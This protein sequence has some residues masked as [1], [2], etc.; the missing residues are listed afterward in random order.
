MA[1]Y[2]LLFGGGS[3]PEGEAAQAQV[4]KAWEAWFTELGSAVADPGNPFTPAAK[5]ISS[6]GS[7]GDAAASA[8]GY[9]V[10][11]ADSLDL[12]AKLATGCPVLQGGATITVF[13]TFEVM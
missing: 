5:K 3:M 13:E 8:S 12:A 2:L 1:K 6:D 9:S 11:E 4:M 7:V 10:I